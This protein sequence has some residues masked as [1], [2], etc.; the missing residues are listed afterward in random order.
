MRQTSN[1]KSNQFELNLNL[2]LNKKI[3]LSELY[4][5]KL[6]PFAYYGKNNIN[7]HKL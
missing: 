7:Y 5:L 1:Y 4:K 6:L 3:I 2:F